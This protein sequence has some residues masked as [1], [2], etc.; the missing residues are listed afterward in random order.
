M[1]NRKRMLFSVVKNPSS[2]VVPQSMA[3]DESSQVFGV[4][5]ASGDS[6]IAT[7]PFPVRMVS[8]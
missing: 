3:T 2:K 1:T 7:K 6:R 8:T 5:G 4:T